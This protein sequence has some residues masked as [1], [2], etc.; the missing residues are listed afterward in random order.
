MSPLLNM[1]TGDSL[2]EELS[3]FPWEFGLTLDWVLQDRSL[4]GLT[5]DGLA[6]GVVPCLCVGQD[7]SNILSSFSHPG[8]PELDYINRQ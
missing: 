8:L 6:L 1:A 7:Y 2:A 5:Q 4:E 3:G